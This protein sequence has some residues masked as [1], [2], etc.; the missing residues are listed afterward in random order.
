MEIF[1]LLNNYHTNDLMEQESK[2]KMLNFLAR[3]PNCFERSCEEGHFT[4]SCWLEN[5][6]RTAIL[7]THHKKFNA[8]LQLGGH[9]DGDSD[10]LR[11]SLKEAFEE[12]GLSVISVNRNIFDVSVHF[13]PPHEDVHQHYHYD[14][15]FY[16]R[17][18]KDEPFVVS[19]E[20][21]DLKWVYEEG[22]LPDNTEIKR[23]FRKWKS[24]LKLDK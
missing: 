2:R 8:W 24:H 6:S 19:D 7:L 4:A 14:V 5:A 21:Y 13:I 15:R 10:L 22:Q 12:S 20:S 3:E 16:L 11:V 1:K 23:M 17:A 18:T 9:A